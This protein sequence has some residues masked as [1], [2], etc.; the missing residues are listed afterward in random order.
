LQ[1]LHQAP[2]RFRASFPL[3]KNIAILPC[4]RISKNVHVCRPKNVAKGF[5]GLVVQAGVVRAGWNTL[6][7]E[8]RLEALDKLLARYKALEISNTDQ[9]V[10]TPLTHSDIYISILLRRIRADLSPSF[11]RYPAEWGVT[12]YTPLHVT[13][14]PSFEK[15]IVY[16]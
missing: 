6:E 15:I 12:A 16:Q 9:G 7:A 10:N 5:Y 2:K 4:A 1:S 14:S 8:A 13:L 11:C 3:F